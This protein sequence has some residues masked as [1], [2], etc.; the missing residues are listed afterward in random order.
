[1]DEHT[2]YAKDSRVA[3]HMWSNTEY[4]VGT[5]GHHMFDMDL[6]GS[7]NKPVIMIG[8]YASARNSQNGDYEAFRPFLNLAM[9]YGHSVC[10]AS[11]EAEDDFTKIDIVLDKPEHFLCK[12]EERNRFMQDELNLKTD[13]YGF[14]YYSKELELEN[15]RKEDLRLEVNTR[16]VLDYLQSMSVVRS[17]FE[18]SIGYMARSMRQDI[19][20]GKNLAEIVSE[21]TKSITENTPDD[22]REVE[23]SALRELA[24]GV[25]KEATVSEKRKAKENPLARGKQ[26]VNKQQRDDDVRSL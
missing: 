6:H 23:M 15:Q 26:S 25:R 11:S 24:D 8:A 5:D 18:E 19:C 4:W 21:Y 22:Y 20:D 16:P 17:S 1:M 10:Q 2:D 9:K 14:P 7:R 3:A 13:E 12:I